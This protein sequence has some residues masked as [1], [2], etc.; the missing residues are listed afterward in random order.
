MARSESNA[1]LTKSTTGNMLERLRL[2]KTRSS[3]DLDMELITNDIEQT[4]TH[5]SPP[6]S[7]PPVSAPS[8][9]SGQSVESILRSKPAVKSTSSFW[10]LVYGSKNRDAQKRS[11]KSGV[12]NCVTIEATVD[13]L[14]PQVRGHLPMLRL[15]RKALPVSFQ[16]TLASLSER[17]KGQN[18]NLSD[19]SRESSVSRLLFLALPTHIDG[20]SRKPDLRSGIL[21]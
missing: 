5:S 18:T 7:D 1:S 10:R 16:K 2:K 21:R 12:A 11:V 17:E 8:S 3:F 9:P 20:R 15:L 14:K 6:R 19:F 13:T 4:H